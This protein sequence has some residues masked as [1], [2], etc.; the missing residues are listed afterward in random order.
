MSTDDL[1]GHISYGFI[2]TVKTL[3]RTRALIRGTLRRDGREQSIK[4]FRDI[5]PKLRE[6][7]GTGVAG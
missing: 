7:R 4:D 1:D 6:D 3:D 2:A 5:A